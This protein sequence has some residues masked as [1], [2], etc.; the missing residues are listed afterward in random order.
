MD[1]QIKINLWY[2]VFAVIGILMLQRFFTDLQQVETIPYSEFQSY[3][4]QGKIS[5]ITVTEK[6]VRGLLKT[7]TPDGKKQFVTTR[8]EP[9]FAK[10]L[11]QYGVTVTGGTESTWLRDILSWIVPMG[12][13]LLIWMFLIRRLAEKQGFGG[14]GLMS[15]GKS[16]AKIYVETD[17][18]VT[19]KDVA[20]VDEAKDELQEIVDF[21]KDPQRY[22][23]LGGR[24]PKG[25]LLVGPPGTG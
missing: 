11:R 10:D 18:K 12:V 13:F 20:G 14:G 24:I 16:R 6:H 5:E 9:A 4:E 23:R 25:V 15:V 1:R 19:F 3:L 8:I 21:L 7:P 2:V 22:G 17:T